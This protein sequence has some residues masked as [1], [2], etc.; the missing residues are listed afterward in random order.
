MRSRGIDLK[1]KWTDLIK[2]CQA[3]PLTVK[4]FAH[5]NKIG[6]GSLYIWSKRLGIALKPKVQGEIGFFELGMIQPQAQGTQCCHV[7]MGVGDLT[8]KT[9][10]PWVR[11]IELIKE[12]C[13]P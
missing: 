1:G 2:M 8:I 9:E 5:E 10:V 7:E 13:K 6:L 4:E 3:S 11:V 12:F